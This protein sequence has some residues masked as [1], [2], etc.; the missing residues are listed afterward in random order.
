MLAPISGTAEPTESPAAR[1]N[2]GGT[3]HDKPA[4]QQTP[5]AKCTDKETNLIFWILVTII[6][7]IA[8]GVFISEAGDSYGIPFVGALIAI[9]VGAFLGGLIFMACGTWIPW[10]NDV[11]KD[12]TYKL[13]AIGNS[14]G[15]EGRSYFLGGGYIKDRRVLNFIS[16]RD[17]GAIYVE[18]ADAARATIFEGSKDAT[19]QAKHIDHVNGWVSPW[20]LG[21]HDEYVFR[22]PTGSVVE[23]YTL[24]NK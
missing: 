22:I 21:S 6:V 16:Q 2:H 3:T 17:G 5:T 14:N 7:L 8:A 10:N 11:V 12:D 1:A 13:K 15:I 4:H 24:D 19:V 18:Q 20:P 23:S 9:V